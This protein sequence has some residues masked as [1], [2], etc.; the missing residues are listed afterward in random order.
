MA[1][2]S[3]DVR[4]KIRQLLGTLRLNEDDE[5]E[6][7]ISID[8]PEYASKPIY[9]PIY[10]SEEINSNVLPAMPFLE[11]E[12]LT[13]M[14]EPQDIGA[15]TRKMEEW[16]TMHFYFTNIDDIVPENFAKTLK[17]YLQNT[18]R[19]NQCS[20]SGITFMN[21]EEERFERETDGHQEVYHYIIT[22]YVLYYD[23]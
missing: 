6:Y 22:L 13:S 12:P 16:I 5:E 8:N 18:I 9:V 20:T 19:T 14:Y 23:I 1:Y 21:I 7:V 15:A 17:D 4:T 10:F 11:L 3:L 2:S